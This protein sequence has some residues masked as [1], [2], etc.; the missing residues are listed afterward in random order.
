M[1]R[2]IYRDGKVY[3]SVNSLK[4]AILH[5][6]SSFSGVVHGR[7]GDGPLTIS[8]LV[9]EACMFLFNFNITES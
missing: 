8:S 3:C 7:P 9:K 2:D 6:F 1:A 4:E 5:A